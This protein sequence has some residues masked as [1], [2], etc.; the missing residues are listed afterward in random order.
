MLSSYPLP[1]VT[2]GVTCPNL[3]FIGS[4]FSNGK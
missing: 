2:L 3:C 1:D 4:G